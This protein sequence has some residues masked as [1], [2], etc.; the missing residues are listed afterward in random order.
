MFEERV[1][2]EYPKNNKNKFDEIMA[3]YLNRYFT[4]AK[5]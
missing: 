4:D 5:R 3:K 1:I 2:A